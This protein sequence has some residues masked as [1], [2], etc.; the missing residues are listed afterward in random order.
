M[1]KDPIVEEIHT[2]REQLAAEHGND[3][4]N[5]VAHVKEV[6]QE[7]GDKIVS[8]PPRRPVGWEHQKMAA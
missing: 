7:H 3:L 5:I 2:I 1:W 6:Q 8:R 4:H